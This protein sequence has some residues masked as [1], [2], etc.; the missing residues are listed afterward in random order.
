MIADHGTNARYNAGCRQHCCKHAHM[1]YAKRAN[2]GH[3]GHHINPTGTH[4]RIHALIAIGYAL[5]DIS[6]ALGKSPTWCNAI[7]THNAVHTNTAQDVADLYNRW[8]MTIPQGWKADRQRRIAA[9]RGWPPPLAW[10]D[11]DNDE[12]PADSSFD[13]SIVDEVK[14]QRVLAGHKQ[15]CTKAEKIAV[16]N[17]WT[18]SQR[19]L[20]LI[21]GWNI[22]RITKQAKVAA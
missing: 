6:V 9:K 14:V 12:A 20:Y 10:D 17:A 22:D 8:H 18:G 4:R 5:T 7:L 3:F 2:L 11:I 15:A 1:I 19:D 16:L 21:T 13:E